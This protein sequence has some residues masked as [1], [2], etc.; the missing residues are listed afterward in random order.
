MIFV[1]LN[2]LFEWLDKADKQL[3]LLVN[4]EWTN[5]FLDNNLPWYR[6]STT[7]LPLYLFILLFI[8]FNYGK[9]ALPW[10]IAVAVTATISDQISSNVLKNLIERPRPCNDEFIQHLG[11]LLLNRCPSSF[12][13]TSS[14]AVNHFTAA[15]FIFITLKPAFGKWINWF[16][17]WA[18]TICYAQVYVG[19]HYPLDV[20]CGGIA[21]CIIGFVAGKLFNKYY[22][23]DKN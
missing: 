18:A 1:F 20:L 13:F 8:I 16:P 21:G 3:F 10:I 17:V 22:S 2:S 5:T 14:H 4:K 19:V 15:F 7:W 12:S 11:R 6:D 9:K 23:L